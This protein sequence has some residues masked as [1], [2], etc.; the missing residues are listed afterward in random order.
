MLVV[1]G[2]A[3]LWLIFKVKDAGCGEYA[4]ATGWSGW[5]KHEEKGCKMCTYQFSPTLLILVDNFRVL[6]GMWKAR[7]RA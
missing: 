1:F 2:I 6:M 4:Q 7:A 3:I 5:L